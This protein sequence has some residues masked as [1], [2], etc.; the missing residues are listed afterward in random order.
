MDRLDTS[1]PTMMQRILASDFVFDFT[2]APLAM[3]AAAVVLFL[4]LSLIHI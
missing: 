3:L 4:F 1:P 2:R